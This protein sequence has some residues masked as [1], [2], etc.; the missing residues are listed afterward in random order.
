M[1]TNGGREKG[2]NWE[3]E[4][5]VYTQLFSHSVVSDSFAT[6]RL[7][8]LDGPLSMEFPRQEYW[9]G[10]PC[11]SPGDLPNPGI[12]SNS[13][14]SAGRFFPTEPPGKPRIHTTMYKTDK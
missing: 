11:L 3:T 10:L 1:V 13:P 6:P 7:V 9:S 12:E 4:T 2:I 14:A 5:D 8:T